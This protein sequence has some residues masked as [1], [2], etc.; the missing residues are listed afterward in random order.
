MLL[1][2]YQVKHLHYLS[3]STLYGIT[4]AAIKDYILDALKKTLRQ[5]DIHKHDKWEPQMTVP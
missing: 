4:T 2:S 3:I 1:F 5:N